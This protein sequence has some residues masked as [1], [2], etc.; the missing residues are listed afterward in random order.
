MI[1]LYI[2]SF[3]DKVPSIQQ[4]HT[5]LADLVRWENFGVNLGIDYHE[6]QKI[7]RETASVDDSKLQLFDHWLNR[8]HDT[9][10][11]AIIRA[12]NRMNNRRLAEDIRTTFCNQHQ[13]HDDL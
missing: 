12:L 10:W 6:I 8:A 3:L 13:N 9:N 4:L 7:K 5:G 11:E 2:L 1:Y